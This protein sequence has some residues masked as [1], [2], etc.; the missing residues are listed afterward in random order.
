MS[1]R[2]RWRG[3]I[4]VLTTVFLITGC[5]SIKLTAANSVNPVL[6]GPVKVLGGKPMPPPPDYDGIVHYMLDPIEKGHQPTPWAAGQKYSKMAK[7]FTVDIV[8]DRLATGKMKVATGNDSS[9]TDYLTDSASS[10]S[11]D[12]PLKTDAAVVDATE[13]D[14]NRSVDLVRINC[15]GNFFFLVFAIVEEMSCKARGLSFRSYSFR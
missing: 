10:S 9:K 12:N 2:I 1:F 5:V 8:H 7:A 11:S 4:A 3:P 15:K 6:L 14:M 13:G